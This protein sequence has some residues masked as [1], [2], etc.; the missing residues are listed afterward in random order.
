MGLEGM[1]LRGRAGCRRKAV[2]RS[3]CPQELQM[4]KEGEACCGQDVA[5]RGLQASTP[6]YPPPSPLAV[7]QGGV[8][9]SEEEGP[10]LQ[11]QQAACLKHPGLCARCP[12][13]GPPAEPAC[14]LWGL[15]APSHCPAA[16]A[17]QQGRGVG[18][19]GGGQGACPGGSAG[20]SLE[21][22]GH[23]IE[24][25]V[26]L[27]LAH[28]EGP[29]LQVR[30][31]DLRRGRVGARVAHMTGRRKAPGKASCVCVC[32]LAEAGGHGWVRWKPQEPV[33][34]TCCSCLAAGS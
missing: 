22:H 25:L 8:L 11:A 4:G 10:S 32:T 7:K 19:G 21:V 20:G 15:L 34:N 13:A 2:T 18:S 16:G 12:V 1:P 31:H 33:R 29:L 23:Q 24:L 17:Q 26:V 6:P 28:G 9:R 5:E 3:A 30:P 27:L 14:A